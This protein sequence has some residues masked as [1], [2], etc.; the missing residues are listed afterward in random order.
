MLRGW[1]L[2]VNRKIDTSNEKHETGDAARL[3]GPAV[4]AG[5]SARPY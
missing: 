4:F 1:R 2:G 5:H 3:N